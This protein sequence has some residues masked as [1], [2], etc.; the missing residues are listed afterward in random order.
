M[1]IAILTATPFIVGGI[2]SVGF[3]FFFEEYAFP[4]T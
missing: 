2:F 4:L 1:W 3:F